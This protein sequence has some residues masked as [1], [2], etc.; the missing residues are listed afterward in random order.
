MF[1]FKR[2]PSSWA[3]YFFFSFKNESYRKYECVVIA[4][5]LVPSF[6]TLSATACVSVV[7]FRSSGSRQ[8]SHRLESRVK[9]ST[10]YL[11]SSAVAFPNLPKEEW[12]HIRRCC[13]LAQVFRLRHSDGGHDFFSEIAN[14]RNKTKKKTSTSKKLT[15]PRGASGTSFENCNARGTHRAWRRRERV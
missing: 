2:K 7:Q 3:L 1:E 11:S 6:S 13:V 10:N 15:F 12:H 14:K 5:C 9:L 4:S 8:L